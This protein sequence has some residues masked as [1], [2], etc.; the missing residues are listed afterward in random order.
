MHIQESYW[1]LQRGHELPHKVRGSLSRKACDI[2][3][4]EIIDMRCREGREEG[5]A[6]TALELGT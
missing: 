1:A 2:F 3:A 6:E 4:E 5:A